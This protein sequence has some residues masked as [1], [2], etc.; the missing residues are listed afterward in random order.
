VASVR[1]ALAAAAAAAAAAAPSAVA[2]ALADGLTAPGQAFGMSVTAVV[3][4]AVVATAVPRGE[5]ALA[6]VALNAEIAGAAGLARATALDAN[7]SH[8]NN[9]KELEAVP[10]AFVD[11]SSTHRQAAADR[12]AQ[13]RSRTDVLAILGDTSD[14]DLPVYRANHTMLTTLFHSDGGALEVWYRANPAAAQPV[15]R[16]T[17]GELFEFESSSLHH[18]GAGEAA[19][20]QQR[21]AP[22]P[23]F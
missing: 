9:Y 20:R 21:E 17:L 8:F 7:M 13:P 14:P 11:A 1:E 6:A 19:V 2:R 3:A 10:V 4:T 15:F 18:L 23:R 12:H 5:V 22:E 16:S